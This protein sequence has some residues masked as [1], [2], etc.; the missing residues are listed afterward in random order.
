MTLVNKVALYP[1]V[2]S[3]K[4]NQCWCWS[5]VNRTIRNVTLHILCH[6][7]K[8]INRC[9][10]NWLCGDA[11][12]DN[13]GMLWEKTVVSGRRSTTWQII[14]E[15]SCCWDGCAML[16]NS[17]GQKMGWISSRSKVTN[18]GANQKPIGIFLLNNN[19]NIHPISHSFQVIARYWSNFRCWQGLSLFSALCAVDPVF[20]IAKFGFSKLEISP[21][22]TVRKVC[23]FS[24]S[25]TVKA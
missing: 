1:H 6:I 8:Q 7:L 12:P 24:R 2:L 23:R 13:T 5:L 15:L 25:W 3:C 20:R 9:C 21:Y 10:I 19:T 22:R 11:R 4:P 14:Q 18:F 16:H 17:I